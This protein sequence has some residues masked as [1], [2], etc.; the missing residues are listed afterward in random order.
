ML[1]D[2]HCHLMDEQFDNDL[3]EV[4]R[5]A[6]DAGVN[7]I[8]I[9]GIDVET[10]KKAIAIAERFDGIYATVGVHPEAAKDVPL[11][12]FDAIRK[13]A[14]HKKVVAIGE[15]GLDYYWD[16]A[17][18]DEQQRV[19]ATQV[20]IAKECGLPV[21]IHNR[22]ATA[23]TVSLLHEVGA[24]KVQGVMHCFMD[25]FE[26]ARR[27]IDM[28]FFISFGGPV[29]FKNAKSVHEVAPL[30]PDES[31]LIE[32]DSPYLAPHPY[33]GKRN[34]PSYVKIVAARMAELKH[35][36]VEQIA[37]VTTKNA[38]RLFGKA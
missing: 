25:T 24:S 32:T 23:D 5:R 17:P 10:S 30:I 27:C 6:H 28:G 26:I 9:P 15:I 20:E 3:D 7:R 38:N 2:T 35:T 31:I 37:D 8:V 16:A 34:E 14:N 22:E 36:S 1:F 4:I 11:T 18:R 13:L 12:A 21:I 33:R 19:M 29:T